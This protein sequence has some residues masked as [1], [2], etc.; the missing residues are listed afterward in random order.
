MS[1]LSNAGKTERVAT[2]HL[3]WVTIAAIVIGV[4]GN[5]ILYFIG[6]AVVGGLLIAFPN[7][8]A[9]P[10]PLLAVIGATVVPGLVAVLMYTLLGRTGRPVTLFRVL[11]LLVLLVSMAP[12]FQLPAAVTVANRIILALMHIW[13]ALVLAGMLTTFGRSRS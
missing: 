4:V 5:L 6:R 2:Q 10:L 1:T 7:A 3:W 12:I 9:M 13:T 8:D 11:A